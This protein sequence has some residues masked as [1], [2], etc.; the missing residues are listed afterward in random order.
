MTQKREHCETAH[1]Q[2]VACSF[3]I[4]ANAKRAGQLSRD[5]A[6]HHALGDNKHPWESVTA[7]EI[8]QNCNGK[9]TANTN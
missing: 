8:V 3:I 1:N 4:G 9:A 5:L 2:L 7:T 6:N